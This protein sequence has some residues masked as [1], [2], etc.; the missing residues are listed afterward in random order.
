MFNKQTHICWLNVIEIYQMHS[1]HCIKFMAAQKERIINNYK[2]VKLKLLKSNA[3]IGYK[4]FVHYSAKHNRNLQ[5]A[6]YTL[7]EGCSVFI[8]SR[9]LRLKQRG[10]AVT[11][12]FIS[13]PKLCFDNITGLDCGS[14]SVSAA[15]VFKNSEYR[16]YSTRST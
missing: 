4:Y 12:Y 9:L 2:N 11:M 3:A 7:Y 16:S 8:C 13:S 14:I 10:Y 6:R 5:N 1:T 15:F